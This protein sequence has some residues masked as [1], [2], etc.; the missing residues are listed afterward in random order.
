[1]FIN[2]SVDNTGACPSGVFSPELFLLGRW[3]PEKKKWLLIYHQPSNCY[4]KKTT[5]HR[6]VCPFQQKKELTNLA[7]SQTLPPRCHLP[8]LVKRSKLTELLTKPVA[9]WCWGM[10]DWMWGDMDITMRDEFKDYSPPQSLTGRP[11]KKWWWFLFNDVC[12][13]SIPW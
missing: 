5:G 13:D 11:C 4:L 1:M 8:R 2:D 10:V 9:R 12:R 6:I 3:F 7:G